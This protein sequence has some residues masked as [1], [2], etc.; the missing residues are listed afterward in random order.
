VLHADAPY[1]IHSDEIT[2]PELLRAAGYQTG[3]I[4]KWHLGDAPQ[5]NPT[6]HG[7][8]EFFGVPYSND[9]EP[10][11]FLRGAERIAEPIDRDNQIRRY[12]D[13]AISFIRKPSR[14][15]VFPVLRSRDA[16]YAARRLRTV[17][18]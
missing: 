9:M 4:G 18:G 1:G 12:T 11:Y 17:P 8:E 6:H 15:A 2:I 10:Y 3:M 16:A 7:F 5:F 14:R 13:E